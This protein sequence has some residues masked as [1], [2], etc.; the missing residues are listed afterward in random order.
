MDNILGLNLPQQHAIQLQSICLYLHITVLLEITN[1]SGLHI[2][3]SMFQWPK[4][5]YI[6]S[7]DDNNG[8]SLHWPY[9]PSPGHT[10]WKCWHKIITWLYVDPATNQLNTPLG[11]WTRDATDYKWVWQVC[12]TTHTLFQKKCSQ[13]C[14][15]WPVGHYANRITYLN[16]ES[17]TPPPQ[18][19]VPATPTITTQLIHLAIPI[20]KMTNLT[21]NHPVIPSLHQWLLTA[22]NQWAEPL[23]HDIW[24]HAH[25]DTLQAQFLNTTKILI[26]SNA[27]IHADGRGTCA[28]T[29]WS[30]T[31]L[32]SGKE[33]I[34]G[35]F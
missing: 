7:H 18:N 3:P 29:I 9:Q 21:P 1:H 27:A 19:T 26:V 32:W 5:Q 12:L 4:M 25:I 20:H 8:S 33:Y 30:N 28:W 16:W 31:E 15:Y 13:W 23:W 14:A 6:A 2:L 35:Q 11:L 10:A 34:P 17:S 22:L 24:L